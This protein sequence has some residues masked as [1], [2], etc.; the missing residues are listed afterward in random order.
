MVFL[1]TAV[2]SLAAL[3]GAATVPPHSTVKRQV[4]Q[5]RNKYDFV[6]VGGGTTGLTV[7]DRL[8]EAFPRSQSR[9]ISSK[10]P[11]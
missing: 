7:A 11:L 4:T 5:L 8:T 1:S 2:V 9:S 6:I 3:A 10:C